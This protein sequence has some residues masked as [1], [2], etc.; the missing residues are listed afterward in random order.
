MCYDPLKVEQ[1]AEQAASA[2]RAGR[3]EEA[4][5]LLAEIEQTVCLRQI[6]RRELARCGNPAAVDEDDLVQELWI[7][8][9]E[10]IGQFDSPKGLFH[11]WATRVCRNL[12]M[13]LLR[14]RLRAPDGHAAVLGGQ[15]DNA[16]HTAGNASDGR[17]SEQVTAFDLD[18]RSPFS[19]VDWQRFCD[20]AESNPRTPV[21][22]VAGF[23]YW[24][25]LVNDPSPDRQAV[26]R[27]WFADAGI[28][29]P[30]EL[31]CRWEQQTDNCDLRERIRLLGER[32]DLRYNSLW[33]DWFRKRHLVVELEFFWGTL[34]Q[35][36]DKFDSKQI[37]LALNCVVD[38]R[39]PVL[40]IDQLWPRAPDVKAWNRLRDGFSFRGTA[41]LL[42]FLELPVLADRID[43]FAKSMRGNARENFIRLVRTLSHHARLREKLRSS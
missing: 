16:E 39:V 32:L 24:K 13:D 28:N 26:W 14:K 15:Q 25:K 21:V 35:H 38:D 10:R 20:W 34:L 41:P 30:E 4:N 17:R 40:G 5:E 3:D 9:N 2:K 8:L 37:E 27:A 33:Q 6:A 36:F 42:R 12:L 31:F 7:R 29:D 18:M 43:L 19:D 1:L 11:I 22:L 23:C